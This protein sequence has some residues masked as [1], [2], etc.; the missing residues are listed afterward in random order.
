MLEERK[1]YYLDIIANTGAKREVMIDSRE[2]PEDYRAYLDAVERKEYII[3][4]PAV[5]V[6]VKCVVSFA[7]NRTENCPVHVNAHG[8]GF[9]IQRNEDDDMYCAHLADGIRGIVVDVEYALCPEYA[10]PVAFE[11]CYEAVKW[12]F[13]KCKE[14]TADENRVSMGGHS[15][16]GNLTAAVALKANGSKDFKLCLQILDYAALDFATDALDKPGNREPMM[17]VERSRA[18]T[19]FYVDDNLELTKSPMVS[20]AF[21][22]DEMLAGLPKALVITAGKCGFRFENEKYGRRMA[23]QGVEVSMKRFLNS[24]HG[25]SVRLV[26]E[27]REAQDLIIR[28]I[29]ESVRKEK[30]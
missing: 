11:Q 23:E 9:V 6:P 30:A 28:Y 14:W 7:K 5:G 16:G 20:P 2:I 4:V 18:F 19:A 22:T 13:G 8:G 1:Q 21:A 12:T 29:R 17:P 3:D 10:F 15:A 27:W 25:F 26:D 24:R